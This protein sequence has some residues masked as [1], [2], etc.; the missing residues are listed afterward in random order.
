MASLESRKYHIYLLFGFFFLV[1][2]SRLFYVQIIAKDFF[3]NRAE[4]DSVS[5]EITF[6][7]RGN[8]YDRN[9]NVLVQ[10]EIAYDIMLTMRDFK[11]DTLKFCELLGIETIDFNRRIRKIKSKK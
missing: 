11:V 5:K 2:L 6:P 3:A 9:G 10:N 1:Y 4:N 8:M 7:P